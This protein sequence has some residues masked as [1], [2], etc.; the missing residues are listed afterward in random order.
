MVLADRGR[1]TIMDDGQAVSKRSYNF[2]ISFKYM[3]SKL[4]SWF[5]DLR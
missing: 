3:G 2:P 5:S 4:G 1:V